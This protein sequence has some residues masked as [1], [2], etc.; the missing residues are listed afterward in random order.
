VTLPLRPGRAG[1]SRRMRTRLSFMLA[2]TILV[3]VLAAVLLAVVFPSRRE[4]LLPVG[5]SAPAFALRTA[6]GTTVSLRRL[7]G[8]VV[9]LEF[10]ASW[11]SRCVAE[12]AVLNYLARHSPATVLYVN[13]DSENAASVAAFGRS[14]HLSVPLLL[15][16][17]PATVSF[18]THGP[19][20][21]LTARYRVTELPTFYVLD[22]R[23][24]VAWRA[25]GV[26]PATPL[27]RQL[28]LAGRSVP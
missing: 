18:P 16:Q 4:P 15:D 1:M 22:A 24:R 8:K 19:R 3:I 11:P 5:A 21:P 9:L 6:T 7:R 27:A 20:G 10:C 12:L 25:A 17:G 23:G 26:Q 13:A 2:G 28:R 14:F